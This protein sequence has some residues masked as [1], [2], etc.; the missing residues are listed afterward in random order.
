MISLYSAFSCLP[1]VTRRLKFPLALESARATATSAQLP[2]A[3][4]ATMTTTP[5][6]A[7]R[8]ASTVLTTL[9]AVSLLAPVRG[10][11][12]T[13]AVADT[14]TTDDA[15]VATRGA[16]TATATMM[17]VA[18]TTTVVQMATTV[19]ATATPVATAATMGAAIRTPATA[20]V[21]PGV[22]MAT[23]V[24]AVVKPAA[25]VAVATMA[26]MGVKALTATE[27]VDPAAADIA[28]SPRRFNREKERLTASA[29]S[30]F[31]L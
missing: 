20:T 27:A 19:A 13:M 14:A 22:A 18:T 25:Q 3:R 9:S 16:M 28:N 29:A 26:V 8:M 23:P 11:A 5:T 17:A 15:G 12:A 7:H 2:F 31:P 6:N 10:T 21:T 4:T 1:Q 24:M 30:R